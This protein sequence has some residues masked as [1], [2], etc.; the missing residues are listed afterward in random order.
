MHRKVLLIETG[1]ILNA[2]VVQFPNRFD[3]NTTLLQGMAPAFHGPIIGK[4]IVPITNV[5]RIGTGRERC[6]GWHAYRRV[7]IG[8]SKSRA[9][10]RKPIEVRGVDMRV[11]GNTHIAWVVFVRHNNKK[12][13]AFVFHT[14]SLGRIVRNEQENRVRVEFYSTPLVFLT[15]TFTTQSARNYPTSTSSKAILIILIA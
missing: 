2:S 10:P 13:W 3:A 11:P 14:E 15:D 6:S 7:C 9:A 12:I 4:R 5:V 8:I 1:I